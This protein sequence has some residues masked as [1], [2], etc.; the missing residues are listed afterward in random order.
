ML[1]L[2]CPRNVTERD[3]R[4]QAQLGTGRNGAGN[5][6]G[7]VTESWKRILDRLSSF[8]SLEN[9]W[10]G[11]GACPPSSELLESAS[12]LAALLRERGLAAPAAVAP[13]PAGT[14]LFVWQEKDGA[15]CE[16]DIE[17]PFWAEVMLVEPGA[18]ACHWT[19]PDDK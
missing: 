18:K 16:V 5:D 19:L 14:I 13:G 6:R 4:G 7:L 15:Y 17:R 2:V 12:A 8:R 11:Q 10:D 9:D 3:W 1:S